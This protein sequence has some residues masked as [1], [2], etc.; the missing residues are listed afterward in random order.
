MED[1]FPCPVCGYSNMEK[2]MFTEK[3][4]KSVGGYLIPTGRVRLQCNYLVCPDCGHK[5]TVDDETFAGPWY[6]I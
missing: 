4:M 2:D 5:E 1:K 6:S 3:E